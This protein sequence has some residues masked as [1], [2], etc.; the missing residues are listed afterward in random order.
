MAHHRSRGLR[1]QL[2]SAGILSVAIPLAL[3]TALSW[4]RGVENARSA[5][6]DARAAAD[7]QVA[8]A[9][10]RLVDLAKMADQQLREQL[11][12]QMSV[13]RA[14]LDRC[15]GFTLDPSATLTWTAKNQVDQSTVATTL[16]Q[17]RLG[18]NTAI[19]Q[20]SDP[21][22]PVPLIDEI[23]RVTTGVATL[24]QRMNP[25]GDMLRVATSVRAADGRRAIG[26]YIPARTA[27]GQA[28]GVITTV[29][30]GQPFVGRAQV[31]GQWMITGYLPLQD[32]NG[33]VVGMLFVG[34][35]EAKAFA[36]IERAV[37]EASLGATGDILILNTKGTTSG[38]AL[39]A[40]SGNVAGQN[41]LDARDT[42]GRSFVREMI[43]QVRDLSATG[44]APTHFAWAR[45]AGAAA[46]PRYGQLAY[47]APWDW[48]IVASIEEQEMLA[49][50][51][52]LE[53]RQRSERLQ[54]LAISVLALA[55]AAGTWLF[56][57]RAIA[58]RIH[59]LADH[60]KA[61][62]EQTT[63]AANQ[64][65]TASQQ[66]AQATNQQAASLEETSAALEET[67]STVKANSERAEHAKKA[68]AN[69]CQIADVGAGEMQ[70]MQDAMRAIQTSSAEITKIVKT[71]DEIAFQTNILAL[72][73]AIEAARA[74]EAGAGFSVV[75]EEVRR[76]AQRSAEAAK[77]TADKIAH[78]HAN[79]QEG[80]ASS[81]QVSK[82]LAEILR[83][84]R[85]VDSIV[86]EIATSTHEQSRAISSLNQT[87]S[88]LD[89]V[90]QSNAASAEESASASEELNAQ[91]VE[92]HQAAEE[93]F[94]LIDGTASE[95]RADAD[96][97]TVRATR[98][99]APVP[100]RSPVLEAASRS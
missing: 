49:S 94:A 56:L 60:I 83:S 14:E 76:L 1:A 64:V 98:A 15:G 28:N 32:A 65:S 12:L 50:V 59:R 97:H 53:A 69:A 92:L 95:S 25:Q 66:L 18:A 79:S 57:G 31:V 63:S 19:E 62:S 80:A 33:A 86:A 17:P 43:A 22:T 37:K 61:G 16:P 24:F 47:F 51:N 99:E 52:A 89:S 42:A 87:V 13:A 78:S 34:L 8:Q 30:G 90:T 75:A 100:V 3:I 93:L 38:H 35:P 55:A 5:T 41:L 72:N 77:E 73:A 84:V 6:A 39:I 26:T 4:W 70:H 44:T 81:E 2:S 91:S 82:H 46:Q 21:L 29:V 54:Q 23:S 67:A 68:V 48:L 9:A 58:R 10:L 96:A 11:E 74:G 27:D 7:A 36:L 85:E 20:V 71:I 45:D 88:Q 40:K